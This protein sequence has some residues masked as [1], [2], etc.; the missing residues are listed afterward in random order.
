M[1]ALAMGTDEGGCRGSSPRW[2]ITLLPGTC[3]TVEA[4]KRFDFVFAL[5]AE[6]ASVARLQTDCLTTGLHHT[7]KLVHFVEQINSAS[8]STRKTSESTP[9]TTRLRP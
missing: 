3:D 9:L 2:P 8:Q 5:R 7:R 4:W 6:E 1:N